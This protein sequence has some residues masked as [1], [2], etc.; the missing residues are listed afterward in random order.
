M[1]HCRVSGWAES[2]RPLSRF[3]APSECV[4]GLCRSPR[5]GRLPACHFLQASPITIIL[6]IFDCRIRHLSTKAMSPTTGKSQRLFSI[7]T[8]RGV[9]QR[10]SLYSASDLSTGG[11]FRPGQTDEYLWDR[12]RRFKEPQ[13]TELFVDFG[14]G[15]DLPNLA[16][17][18]AE[19]PLEVFDFA[20]F[21]TEL[22]AQIL[23]R[24][25]HTHRW[26]PRLGTTMSK[27]C[28]SVRRRIGFRAVRF[29]VGLAKVQG[30]G[31]V[32]KG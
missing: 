15:I 17:H 18:V 22:V 7:G 25:T 10:G 21:L 9:I 23:P 13:A 20:V 24:Q 1:L 29:C 11:T 26:L 2:V 31:R 19:F 30:N 8:L 27:Y 5:C 12:G 14:G 16:E 32:P 6:P 3:C 4:L 28:G